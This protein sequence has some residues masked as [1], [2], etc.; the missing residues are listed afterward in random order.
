MR[1]NTFPLLALALTSPCCRVRGEGLVDD[2]DAPFA[3][4]TLVGNTITRTD[5]SDLAAIT[6]DIRDMSIFCEDGDPN[7]A[8]AIYRDGKNAAYSLKELATKEQH[9]ENDL[10]FA[11]QMYGLSGGKP[12]EAAKYRLFASEY[13]EQKFDE[14]NCFAAVFAAQHMILWMH[15]S[16]AIWNTVMSCAIAA[17]PSFDNEAAGVDNMPAKADEIVAYWVGL[18]QDDAEGVEGYSLY[19]STN[20]IA[21]AF[22]TDVTGGA[23][24]NR[25]ILYAY[26]V[27]SGILSSEEA[28]TGKTKT[29]EQ[30]WPYVTEISRQT[31]V[32][33]IQWLI[34]SMVAED[35]ESIDLFARIVVP[36]VSQCRY[37][38]YTYLKETFL[39][40]KYE[41][42]K[43]HKTLKVLQSV[44][45]CLGLTC[46]D[47]GLPYEKDDN[48]LGCVDD[49]DPPT[50]AG[51]PASTDVTEQSK[52]DLDMHQINVL[53]RQA[54]RHLFC[55]IYLFVH[56][57]HFTIQCQCQHRFI[58][59]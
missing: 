50:I 59:T 1:L 30:L 25:N 32:P 52:I 26:E 57:I 17:D 8:R 3:G 49:Y 12:E 7:G 29:I 4:T 44:Y 2:D 39:D 22:G 53:V 9:L 41:T 24:A 37:S 43:F 47:I 54:G 11:F 45:S 10:T 31:L 16:F 27:V 51:Y 40:I 34:D 20:E 36:Q 6:I 13:V 55:V 19:S 28:C 56:I 35:L 14:M 5:V 33:Q 58:N 15:T 23:R 18:I 38:S 48:G 21:E 46:L 42:S